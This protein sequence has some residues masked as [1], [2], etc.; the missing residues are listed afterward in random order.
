MK[1]ERMRV[2]IAEEMGLCKA[3]ICRP[4]IGQ[5]EAALADD[6]NLKISLMPDGSVL[7]L[8]DFPSCLNAMREALHVCLKSEQDW[9]S[10]SVE[11][12]ETMQRKRGVIIPP[13]K[14]ID[15]TSDELA[16][17]LVRTLGKREE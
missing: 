8:P 17:T 13:W 3:P 5:I 11:L 16:E 14:L 9:Q 10:F 6:G 1:P 2:V 12:G 7:S 4:S 15:A